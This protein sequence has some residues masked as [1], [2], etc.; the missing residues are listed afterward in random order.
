MTARAVRGAVAIAVVLAGRARADD[1]SLRDAARIEPTLRWPVRVELAA[2]LD[3]DRDAIRHAVAVE[4]NDGALAGTADVEVRVSCAA[5]GVD[6]GVVLEVHRPDSARRYRYAL[7]WHAQPADARPRLVGLAVAEAVEASRIE[8]TAVPEPPV[9]IFVENRLPA[10]MMPEPASGWSLA[11][12]GAR[13]W[14]A[15]GSRLRLLGG[16]VMASRLVSPRLRL[17][18]D[19][20]VESQ[21]LVVFPGSVA[22]FSMSSAPRVLVRAGGR[23]HGEIGLGARV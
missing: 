5:D 6:A 4:L 15:T 17:A 19:L 16:G 21:T 3:A 2:C 8:L 18:V 9:H 7:D 22:V 23:L 12:V 1:L 13:R 10:A 14:F 11:I 20:V